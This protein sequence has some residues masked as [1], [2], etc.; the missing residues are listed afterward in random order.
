MSETAVHSTAAPAAGIPMRMATA[1]L[2]W[3]SRTISNEIRN[4][5]ARRMVAD[6]AAQDHPGVMADFERAR[7]GH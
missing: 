1:G 6:V 3:L 5:S 7:S 4:A 2:S